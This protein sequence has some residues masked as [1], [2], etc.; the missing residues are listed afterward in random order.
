[1]QLVYDQVNARVITDDDSKVGF[2][3]D[4]FNTED[5]HCTDEVVNNV[6][7]MFNKGLTLVDIDDYLL[8]EGQ[9]TQDAREVIV[10]GLWLLNNEAPHYDEIYSK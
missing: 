4:K 10:E 9:C 7:D 8:D 1:M 2:Y 3:T 6:V 5:Y